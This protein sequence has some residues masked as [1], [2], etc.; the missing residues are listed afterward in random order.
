MLYAQLGIAYAIKSAH[1]LKHQHD[2]AQLAAA[3]AEFSEKLNRR[4][5]AVMPTQLDGASKIDRGYRRGLPQRL[6][7][8]GK[9]D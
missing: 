8:D 5:T 1:L 7:R 3:A 4:A 2:N 9:H 6:A